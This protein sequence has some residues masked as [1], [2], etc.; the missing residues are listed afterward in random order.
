MKHLLALTL[1]CALPVAGF[2]AGSDDSSAPKQTNTTKKCA[3]GE[4]WDEESKSCVKVEGAN[5]LGDDV[6]YGAV[7]ELA[8]A[9]RVKDAQIALA[10]MSNQAEDRVLT[11]WGFTH[12]K[13]GNLDTAMVF[14]DRA[15]TQNPDNLLA[16]SYMGQAHVAAGAY[17]LARA[18]LRE[19]RMRGGRNT[20]AEAS[21][22]LALDSG[23]GFNY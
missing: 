20:W 10:A 9:G 22:R 5:H 4:L 12:R 7:R 17:D 19:I 23:R 1:S 15:L 8:Y 13:L 16:R 3:A 6:L 18:E 2:A 11:Y 21:L 14:Y